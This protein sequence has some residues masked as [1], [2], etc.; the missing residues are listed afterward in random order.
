VCLPTV[1]S[2]PALVE[3]IVTELDSALREEY[4]QNL[5]AVETRFRAARLEDAEAAKVAGNVTLGHT[6]AAAD[7]FAGVEGG[8]CGGVA[9]CMM[10]Q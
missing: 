4:R 3:A 7:A 8:E 2:H 6:F 1:A 5:D 9:G 10:R